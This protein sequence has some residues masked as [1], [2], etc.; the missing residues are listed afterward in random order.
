MGRAYC[1]TL[2]RRSMKAWDLEKIQDLS[3]DARLCKII[4]LIIRKKEDQG[5]S[6]MFYFCSTVVT[7]HQTKQKLSFQLCDF[8][9]Y[10]NLYNWIRIILRVCT[11]LH[12]GFL[13]STWKRVFIGNLNAS[14]DIELSLWFVLEMVF[15]V[16]VMRF[17]LW[18][19]Q[20]ITEAEQYKSGFSYP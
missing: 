2:G 6:V 17:S 3:G 11:S 1:P 5:E 7:F 20:V 12:Y 9:G 19:C 18:R 14:Q 13:C 10:I 15:K 4:M 8:M 16:A